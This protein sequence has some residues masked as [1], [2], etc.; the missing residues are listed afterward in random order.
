MTITQT[1]SYQ[2]LKDGDHF[3]LQATPYAAGM[4]ETLDG[5]LGDNP[6]SSFLHYEANVT[7]IDGG[8]SF[9]F[10]QVHIR[11]A[12]RSESEIQSLSGKYPIGFIRFY[13]DR[14]AITLMS[15]SELVSRM[16]STLG[17]VRSGE[18]E[19]FITLPVLP[20]NVSGIY[21]VLSYQYR[22]RSVWGS[23][24]A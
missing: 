4:N 19:F 10:R 16:V 13:E 2:E 21:P 11:V 6:I 23:Q 18:M 24:N 17:M 15:R 7:A 20:I 14:P 1:L 8:H 12:E 22:S 9:P 3:W 5:S